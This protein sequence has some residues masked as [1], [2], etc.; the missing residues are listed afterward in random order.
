ML[1]CLCEDINRTFSLSRPSIIIPLV[2]T[3][4]DEKVWETQDL[5]TEERN[6]EILPE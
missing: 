3:K 5:K 6:N 1:G 2:S 4:I